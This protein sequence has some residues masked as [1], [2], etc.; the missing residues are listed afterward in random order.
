M[1]FSFFTLP[2][3]EDSSI[4][5]LLKHTAADEIGWLGLRVYPSAHSSQFVPVVL[6]IQSLQTASPGDAS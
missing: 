1:R 5:H 2:G 4:H 6:C 3:G